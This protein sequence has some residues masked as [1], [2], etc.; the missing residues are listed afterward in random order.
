[1]KRHS[2]A[3]IGALALAV[4]LF[5]GTPA[6]AGDYHKGATLHCAECHVMHASQSHGYNADGS[7]WF[8][9]L[10]GQPYEYLLRNSINELCLT[11]HNGSTYA[12]DVL[13]ANIISGVRLG[14]ALNKN[15]VAPYFDSTGHTLGTVDPAPGGTWAPGAEHGLTCIDCHAQHG[16]GSTAVANG[17]RNLNPAAGGASV[18]PPS[19][20]TGTNDTTKDVFERAPA[21]YTIADV[22]FNEPDQTKSAYAS[23][24]GACH[25]DFHGAVGSTTIGGTGGT[26]FDR[27]PSA[28]VNIGAAGGGHSSTAVFA[29]GS[30]TGTPGA[31]TSYVK[32]MTA[33]GNW[34][35][36]SAAEV[37]DHTPSCMSCHKAHGNQNPFGLI[38]M[39][40]T[41][42]ITGEGTAGGIYE[43]LCRQCHV[44]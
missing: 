17:Y 12:P 36:Q 31:K 22:D 42:A 2:L 32:V 9:P 18:N 19:Y 15:N 29:T 30:R 4:V 28:G 24:C 41:G 40:N 23:W 35:P 7:G 27:H 33:T 8:V 14:G 5:T 21:A 43:D 1:M 10:G 34:T 38:Y 13:E 25:S 6:A 26:G 20:A 37:T 11:C 16:R 3:L 39:K 44:Q